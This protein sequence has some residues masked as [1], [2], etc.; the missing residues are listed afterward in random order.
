LKWQSIKV[1]WGFH[2]VPVGSRVLFLPPECS[3]RLSGILGAE[4]DGAR[5]DSWRGSFTKCLYLVAR[6]CHV[7]GQCGRASLHF[8]PAYDL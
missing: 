2:G 6:P 3:F 1:G 7:G 4:V 5:D 8:A